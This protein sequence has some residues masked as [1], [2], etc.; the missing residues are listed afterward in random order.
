MCPNGHRPSKVTNMV[1]I[2]P[3][4]PM[5][6]PL[7]TLLWV[8]TS[9]HSVS[10]SRNNWYQEYDYIVG[11]CHSSTFDWVIRFSNLIEWFD[12]VCLCLSIGLSVCSGFQ[13]TFESFKMISILGTK[14]RA[15]KLLAILLASN[16]VRF[17]SFW[18]IQSIRM[19]NSECV[20]TVLKF[21]H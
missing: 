11:K 9:D 13:K 7:A 20:H 19:L 12:W 17:D 6:L 5:I 10:I 8:R 2:A 18:A 3:L 16:R 14:P 15:K 4:L 21:A 1:S